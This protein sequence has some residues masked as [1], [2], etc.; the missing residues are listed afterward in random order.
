M[1]AVVQTQVSGLKTPRPSARETRESQ[2]A[3]DLGDAPEFHLPELAMLAKPKPRS[4]SV[5][6]ES[7]RQNARMLESVL[8][9]FGVRGADRP[10][11][12]GPRRHPL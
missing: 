5:D 12:P 4:S 9:E 3:L 10:D 6:E 2:N 8:A 11:P 7:L 1:A